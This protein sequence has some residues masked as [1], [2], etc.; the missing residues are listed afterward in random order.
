MGNLISKE[1]DMGV[2]SPGYRHH[3]GRHR[4]VLNMLPTTNHSDDDHS[5][6]LSLNHL[7]LL[8]SLP[9]L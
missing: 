5:T 4:H 8:A 6:K 1:D 2:K 3:G 9:V 7:H